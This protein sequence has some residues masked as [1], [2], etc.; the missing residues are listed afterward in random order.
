MEEFTK[1]LELDYKG[2]L[3]LKLDYQAAL[4]RPQHHPYR[5]KHPRAPPYRHSRGLQ[6]QAEY[7]SD[8]REQEPCPS[9]HPEREHF[10]P[11][12]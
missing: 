1:T 11:L 9:G 4:H 6:E 12:D 3:H 7:H 10:G 8:P 2:A 5:L